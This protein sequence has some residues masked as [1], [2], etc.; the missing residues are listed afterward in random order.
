MDIVEIIRLL[1]PVATF[2]MGYLLTS[3]GYR[4]DRKLAIVREKFEKLYHPFYLLMHEHG[5]DTAD[6]EGLSLGGDDY[7]DLKPLFDHLKYN[8]YLASPEGQKLFWETRKAFYSCMAGGD[9]VDKEA[10]QKFDQSFGMLCEY[11][12]MEYIKCAKALGYELGAENS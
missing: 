11:L 6:G 5:T 1:I 2:A 3:I 7:S 9:D 10:E 12:L 8:M 4:R